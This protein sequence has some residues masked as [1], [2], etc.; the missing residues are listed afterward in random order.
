DE[1]LAM[2]EAGARIFIEAGPGKVL[3]GLAAKTLEG[4]PFV[5]VQM[6]QSGRDGLTQLAHALGQ[7]SVAGVQFFGYRMFEGRVD[8]K[9]PL[10]KLLEET[11]PKPLGK[12]DWLIKHGRAAPAHQEPKSKPKSLAAAAGNGVPHVVSTKPAA[13][14]A[15]PL[16]T[17]ASART[18]PPAP[19]MPTQSAGPSSNARDA[20]MDGHQQLMS[21]FLDMHRTVMLNYLGNTS[22]TAAPAVAPAAATTAVATIPEPAVVAAAAPEIQIEPLTPA[23]VLEIPAVLNRESVT[24]AILNI[25]SER[26]G[27]PTEMLGL[28]LDL[29]AELGVDSIKR[30]EIF[31]ALQTA[32][33]LPAGQ[34]EMESLSKLKTLRLIV[35]AITAAPNE[36]LAGAPGLNAT[37]QI[38]TSFEAHTDAQQLSRMVPRVVDAPNRGAGVDPESIGTVL[39]TDDGLGVA[40]ALSGRLSGLGIASEIV[41]AIRP[42]G[43]PQGRRSIGALIH[44]APLGSVNANEAEEIDV[45]LDRD[46]RS[47]FQLLKELSPQLSRGTVLAATALGGT[48]A[49]DS[50]EVNYRP[51]SASVVGLMKTLQREWPEASVKT[52]DFAQGQPADK[53]A[54]VLVDELLTRGGAV[55]VGYSNGR[56]KTIAAVP[57]SSASKTPLIEL[58]KGSVVVITGGARGITAQT[59]LE[60]ARHSQSTLV[61]I[62]RTP[63]GDPEPPRYAQI[64]DERK[65]KAA[66]AESLLALGTKPTPATVEAEWK[67]IRN[68]R[69]IR[70]NLEELKNAGSRVEYHALDVTDQEAFKNCLNDIY[71]RLGRIDGVIHGAGVIEDKLLVDK[72]PESFDRVLGPKVV[73]AMT[74]LR[75]VRLDSLKFLIFYSSVSARYGNRGQCDYAAA[76]EVLNKLA[77]KWNRKLAARVVSINWGPWESGGGMVTAELRE[78]FLQAGV[79]LVSPAAGRRGFIQEL[80]HER[81]GAEVVWGGPIPQPAA[82]PLLSGRDGIHR[83][84][85]VSFARTLETD[86][87]RDLY[88]Q[89]HTLDGTPVMPFAMAMEF[90]AES[91][92]AAMPGMELVCLREVRVQQGITYPGD[93][94][95]K[96]EIEG[97]VAGHSG[98]DALI[99]ASIKSGGRLHYAAQL[100]L[101]AKP[102]VVPHAPRLQL[103]GRRAASISVR[104]AYESWLFHGPLFEGIQDI[105]AMGENGIIGALRPSSPAMFLAGS[106]SSDWLIDPLVIDSGLQLLI[107]WSRTYLDQT[108][109][110]ARLGAFHRYGSFGEG[111]VR[112]EAEIHHTTGNPILR[113][114][115]RFFDS[116]GTL[117]GVMQDMEVTCSKSLNRLEKGR[118]IAV[119]A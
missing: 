66:I 101:S 52:L 21:K 45:E 48:F 97:E 79:Q 67:R 7:L 75:A 104:E 62:G 81:G 88:L 28:D 77:A 119:E 110:P 59:A 85:P 11:R 80:F 58:D 112:C 36:E 42:N 109:L 65:L 116:A 54:A 73:G 93:T 64:T 100:E 26:T 43:L 86:P 19:A 25:V 96:I 51:L 95:Q 29:E 5:S 40:Q 18:A 87:G 1:I 49:I 84:S 2:Y 56:R 17:A 71:S 92:C 99:Q 72:T 37:Q 106:P 94:R 76:N 24:A 89:D 53:I 69:E 35:D 39:I 47:L 117:A 32:S 105:E 6:E 20:V 118:A 63:L 111:P 107:I 44:L 30:V 23:V 103:T 102:V 41:A 61:L 82:R 108:P 15:T 31:G 83:E 9:L 10:A 50:D 68:N 98:G 16:K 115:L 22:R 33:M 55:E 14:D 91:A 74:L 60:L 113:C 8:Y 4:R 90:L 27:Y 78:K 13:L 34:I 12:T 46:L 114:Q 38:Q 57:D 3:S 70:N